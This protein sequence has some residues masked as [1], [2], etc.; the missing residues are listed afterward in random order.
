M[1]LIAIHEHHNDTLIQ[2]FLLISINAMD[3][4]LQAPQTPTSSA[5]TTHCSSTLPCT[6]VSH[7][8]LYLFVQTTATQSKGLH[9][10]LG[11]ESW[12]SQTHHSVIRRTRNLNPRP[13][14][15]WVA[16]YICHWQR[17]LPAPH[18]INEC[19]YAH[20]SSVTHDNLR[21]NAIPSSAGVVTGMACT[22]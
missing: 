2:G 6:Y 1:H 19:I 8:P 17:R 7:Q 22:S 14:A 9:F 15:R 16:K 5:C 12:C 21:I 20:S 13:I 3:R 4:S 18:S 11:T 10:I